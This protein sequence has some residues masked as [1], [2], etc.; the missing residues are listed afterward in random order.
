MPDSARGS[1]TARTRRPRGV[2]PSAACRWTGVMIP[3]LT[4]ESA[5]TTRARKS[6]QATAVV[7]ASSTESRPGPTRS[8]VQWIRIA[9]SWTTA[10]PSATRTCAPL[11][12]RVHAP[13]MRRAARQ[14]SRP[15]TRAAVT[16]SCGA[17]GTQ[18]HPRRTRVSA[19][20]STA[21][22]MSVR[23]KPLARR[24][25]VENNPA[26]IARQCDPTLGRETVHRREVD[27]QPRFRE[28]GTRRPADT[29]KRCAST[30]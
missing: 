13:W 9:G 27:K 18:Y 4:R 12:S 19:P 7:R 16:T 20:P 29:L 17:D 22:R 21:R 8:G 10:M 6:T 3:R 24:C 28:L 23:C 5:T 30:S 15:P 11:T 2:T 25:R 1:C 26:F 14:V